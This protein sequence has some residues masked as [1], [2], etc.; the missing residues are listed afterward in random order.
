M[1]DLKLPLDYAQFQDLLDALGVEE[2]VAELHG[3]QTGII[4]GQLNVDAKLC[5][6]QLQKELDVAKDANADLTN[7]LDQ[8]F[9]HTQN[10]LKDLEFSFS[11]LLPEDEDILLASRLLCDW[12][13]G[14]L[15]GLA[16]SGVREASLKH[17]DA[18][19]AFQD[20]SQ[21]AY[22]DVEVSEE[23]EDERYLFELLEYV[24]V[25]VQTLHIELRASLASQSGEN[26]DTIH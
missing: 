19:E 2:S 26:S 15:C 11:P 22:A 16:L 20:L 18:K 21:I 17:E 24:R 14:F 12:C 9:T 1:T 6:S 25:A 8:L 7:Q 10:Q 3:L 5:T 4:C 13:R 23:T